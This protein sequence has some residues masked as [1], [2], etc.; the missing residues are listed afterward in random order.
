[1]HEYFTSFC[2]YLQRILIFANT[3]GKIKVYKGNEEVTNYTD[4]IEPEITK[5]EKD[6]DDATLYRI[7]EYQDKHR[8][9]GIVSLSQ[10]KSLN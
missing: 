9:I 5:S 1:M 2:F 7:K 10:P 8:W 3:N 4:I 6:F